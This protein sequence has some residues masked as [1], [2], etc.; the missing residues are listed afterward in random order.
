MSKLSKFLAKPKVCKIGDEELE[1]HPLTF[2]DIDIILKLEDESKKGEA[3]LDLVTKTLKKSIPDC[4]DDE[5]KGMSIEYLEEVLNAV[6]SVNKLDDS[7]AKQKLFERMK[8]SDE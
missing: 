6:M 7:G 2:G 5:I 1:I 3:L 8:K 4:T